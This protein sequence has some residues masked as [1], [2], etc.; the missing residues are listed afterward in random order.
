VD[1]G[2]RGQGRELW[3]AADEGYVF[4][5]DGD[6]VERWPRADPPIACA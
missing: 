3:I 1:T 4:V 2:W 6:S 5:V